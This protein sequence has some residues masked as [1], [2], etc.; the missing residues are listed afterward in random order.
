MSQRYMSKLVYEVP[1]SL[2]TRLGKNLPAAAAAWNAVKDQILGVPYPRASRPGEAPRK[3]TGKLQNQ[4]RAIPAASSLT[5]QIVTTSVGKALDG[6]TKRVKARPFINLIT[7]RSAS[8]L[9]E[10][11]YRK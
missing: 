9:R 6:G 1:G 2:R 10:A 5:I 8:A 3:R 7:R 4:T 11:L